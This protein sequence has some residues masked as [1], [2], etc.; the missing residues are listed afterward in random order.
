MTKRAMVVSLAVVA[1]MALSLGM[2]GGAVGQSEAPKDPMAAGHF[3]GTYTSVI[4]D[5]WSWGQKQ[6]QE[7]DGIREDGIVSTTDPRI[8]GAWKQVRN[9][10]EYPAERVFVSSGSAR[11]DNPDGSWT[12]TFT[13]AYDHPEATGFVEEWNILTG[14]GAYDGLTALFHYSGD[15][16][17]LEGVIVPSSDLPT[18]PDPIAKPAG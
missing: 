5:E 10:L 15:G 14:S 9:I 18:Q 12:G 8:N 4:G 13:G 11:I 1:V 3:T 16:S 7:L 17:T 6:G 2:G